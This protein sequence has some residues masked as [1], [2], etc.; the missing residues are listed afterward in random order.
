[1]NGELFTAREIA[2]WLK[3]K[4]P[5]IRKWQLQGLPCLRAG[6]L[7]RYEKEQVREWL[8]ERAAKREEAK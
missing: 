2:G 8:E 1:M 6:R 7:C 3:I 4:L 5:T